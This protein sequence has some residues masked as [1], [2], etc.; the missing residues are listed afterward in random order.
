MGRM[1]L[2]LVIGFGALFM[3]F[4]LNNIKEDKEMTSNAYNNFDYVNA[5]NIAAAGIELAFSKLT[6]DANWTGVKNL[7]FD[8][9]VL[10]II[11]TST[12]SKYPDGPDMGLTS[13]KQINSQG[14]VGTQVKVIKTVINLAGNSSIPQFLS[15]AMLSGKDLILNGN[16]TI[17]DDGNNNW[18]SDVHANGTIILNGNNNLVNGFGTFSGSPSPINNNA[19]IKTFIPNQNPDGDPVYQQTAPV[20]L[21]NFK[22]EDYKKYATIIESGN[23]IIDKNTSLGS[24]DNPVIYYVNGDLTVRAGITFTGYGIFVV[25]GNV[26]A[27]GNLLISSPD[28]S[29]NN[30]AIYAEGEVHIDNQSTIY[31]QIISNGN[32]IFNGNTVLH[33]LACSTAGII[34]NGS[35]NNIYYRPSGANLAS[36]FQTSTGKPV[37]L[38]YYE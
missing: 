7:K 33:G 11:V 9:G 36:I 29:A 16:M 24:K 4:N 13:A 17:T 37:I 21:P 2:F 22:A 14:A 15:Y 35:N 27:E 31:A 1:L 32:L 20:K 12:K 18:N 8:Q 3:I 30:L 19:D 23:K 5:K 25:K 26:K 10:N 6:K 34:L 28:K 38:S